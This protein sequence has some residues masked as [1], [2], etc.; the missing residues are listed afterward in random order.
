MEAS[1]VWLTSRGFGF[2]AIFLDGEFPGRFALKPLLSLFVDSCTSANAIPEYR[3]E[4]S[5]VQETEEFRCDCHTNFR[6]FP[7][8]SIGQ[9]GVL[10]NAGSAVNRRAIGRQTVLINA[11]LRL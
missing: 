10:P 6:A 1:G 3:I 2:A 7:R 4:R 8:A 9:P 5:G 11:A